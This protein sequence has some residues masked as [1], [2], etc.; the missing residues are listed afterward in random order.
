MYTNVRIMYITHK[1]EWNIRTIKRTKNL[2]WI[3]CKKLQQQQQQLMLLLY[4]VNTKRIKKDR[5]CGKLAWLKQNTMDRSQLILQ[6]SLMS[7]I[8]WDFFSL[9]IVFVFFFCFIIP[10][11][12]VKSKYCIISFISFFF[13]SNVNRFSSDW[14]IYCC[15]WFHVRFWFG[16]IFFMN[17]RNVRQGERANDEKM[18]QIQ[19]P[20]A[21]WSP[22][23]YGHSLFI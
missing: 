7:T 8:R 5:V 16:F 20:Y 13:C 10:F 18:A 17:F 22:S 14:L 23:I 19:Y 11:W 1:M 15:D 21:Q 3:E 4:R 2:S 6:K 9:F 12:L